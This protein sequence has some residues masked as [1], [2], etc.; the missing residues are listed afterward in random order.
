M[1]FVFLQ[2]GEVVGRKQVDAKR[3]V[4]RQPLDALIYFGQL[5]EILL[6]RFVGPDEPPDVRILPL[7]AQLFVILGNPGILPRAKLTRTDGKIAQGVF[8]DQLALRADRK[9]MATRMGIVEHAPKRG[10]PGIDRKQLI[11]GNLR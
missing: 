9:F 11:I 3:L 1:V 6:R 10:D 7:R 8:R 5:W 2:R 4:R